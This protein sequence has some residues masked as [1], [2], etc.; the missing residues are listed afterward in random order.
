M[1]KCLHTGTSYTMYY[2]IKILVI[3]IRIFPL[4]HF[5]PTSPPLWSHP[6]D[7]DLNKF[8]S[9]LP[10]D[11]YMLSAHVNKHFYFL[12]IVIQEKDLWIPCYLLVMWWNKLSYSPLVSNDRAG[13]TGG[14]LEHD[15]GIRSIICFNP[16]QLC[17]SLLDFPIH[18]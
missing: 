9:I 3:L 13:F 1:S 10:G 11:P 16:E 7:H 6:A 2:N 4:W 17:T 14:S 8:K 15:L 12:K 5:Q 18:K